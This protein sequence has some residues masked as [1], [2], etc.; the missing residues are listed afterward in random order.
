MPDP[1]N[2]GR[3][4]ANCPKQF[5]GSTSKSVVCFHWRLPCF[6][7]HRLLLMLLLSGTFTANGQNSSSGP[8]AGSD[9][10]NST[11]SKTETEK[12][13]DELEALRSQLDALRARL[14]AQS[15]HSESA[16]APAFDSSSKVSTQTAAQ[17]PTP[18]QPQGTPQSTGATYDP[19]IA[20]ATKARGGDLS[21][22][23]DLLRT[24]RITLGGYGDFQ[25]RQGSLNE[26]DD[27]GGTSTFQSTRFVLGVAAV[28][29]EKQNIVFNSEIE[30]ELGTSEIDVEQVFVAWKM[31]PEFEF[32][33]GIIV[34]ALGRFNSFHD[35]NLNL[36]TLRPLMNQYIIPTAYRDTG[37]GFRGR[38]K[39]PHEM[40]LFYEADVLNG[41]Q[42]HNADGIA[43]PF[44]RLV[45]QSSAAEPGLVGFQDNN[46]SKAVS[47]RIGFSPLLGLEFGGSVYG[48]KFDDLGTAP[49][50]LTIAVVDG[51]Y[52]HG[53]LILNGEYARSN[54]V[55]TGI[56]RNSPTPPV[57]DTSVDP[58]CSALAQFVAQTSPGQDGF[59]LEGAY[60]FFGGLF[61]SHERF[62]SGAYIA[63]VFRYE[64]VRLDRTIPNFYLNRSRATFGL[65]IAPS[66]SIIFKLNYA[67][68]HT[69]GPVPAV[70]GPT[71]H[72]DF[73]NNPVP[74]LDYGKN[75][76]V[77]SIAYVF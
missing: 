48:A 28:L 39:L 12:L 37:L 34:P 61:R 38:F 33:G 3:S 8:S 67:V 69:F 26:R 41:F 58:S 60:K 35:S 53:P 2:A 76:F 50:S 4:L 64:A 73:G 40:R 43:T 20:M 71:K 11:G 74:F 18:E 49:Q 47:G 27:G 32:R 68:N 54:I 77:G 51:S 62:D 44:S 14:D 15:V 56:A 9:G 72:S 65:N 36:L 17:K 23:G 66:P 1:C 24:Q 55:G 22:S 46:N 13:R 52:Q 5:Q 45:G 7:R 19:N 70:S 21:G 75:G 42:A 30:Y 59:Y 6:L 16:V 10:N 29:S 25:F 63:P 57:C 31:R